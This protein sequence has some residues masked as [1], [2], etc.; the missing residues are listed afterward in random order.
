MKCMF[1]KL[2]LSTVLIIFCIYDKNSI[3]PLEHNVA[4]HHRQHG[5]FFIVQL[6]WNL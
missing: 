6:P 1:V 2:Y 3:T 5:A 4:L